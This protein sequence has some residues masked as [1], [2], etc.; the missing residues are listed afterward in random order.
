MPP[1]SFSFALRRAV[2][3]LVLLSVGIAL[4]ACPGEAPSRPRRDGRTT[5]VPDRGTSGRRDLGILVGDGPTAPADDTGAAGN[6]TAAGTVTSCSPMTGAGCS[7]GGGCYVL[8]TKGT[9][10][11]CPAGK[12]G[13]GGA[14][15]TSAECAP[16][17]GC[18]GDAPP[19]T[20]RK[21]CDPTASDCG[22][23]QRCAP[24]KPYPQYGMC[25]PQ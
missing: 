7:G 10:C 3:F 12:T 8:S 23:G 1:R 17:H 14:C 25:V 6:C 24:V 19:G 2:A 20:C 5:P 22:G 9:A 15:Q 13:A 18:A 11:V 4:T 21:W 16:G